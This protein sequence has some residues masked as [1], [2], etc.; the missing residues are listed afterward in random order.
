[1]KRAPLSR[2]GRKR[3]GFTLIE[4]LVVISII[5]TLAA[6]ITPAVQAARRAAQN[7]QCINN[8]RNVGTATINTATSKRGIPDLV[9][10]NGLPWTVHI[11]GALEMSNLYDEL[12]KGVNTNADA[13]IEAFRCPG[14]PNKARQ[15]GNSYVANGGFNR[16]GSGNISVPGG[17]AFGGTTAGSP[18]AVAIGRA[19]GVFMR[20]LATPDGYRPTFDAISSQDGTSNTIMI[21]ENLN[22]GPWASSNAH[23][24]GFGLLMVPAQ[25]GAGQS[26]ALQTQSS[27]AIDDDSKINTG[28]GPR[29]SSVHDGTVNVMLCD[30]SVRSLSEEVDVQIYAQIVTSNGYRY[31]EPV[32]RV[33][34]F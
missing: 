30:G 25:M 15:G 7:A 8:M 29:P 23:E 14:D 21:S 22:A 27:A 31:G 26:T 10:A 5:A 34:P 17:V 3:G 11:L 4:L 6:L 18:E 2:N 13:D 12:R 19:S 32:L 33:R 1:M 28:T 9:D 24:V 20:P 16:D